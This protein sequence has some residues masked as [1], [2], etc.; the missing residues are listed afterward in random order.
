MVE[1]ARQL[2]IHAALIFL[3]PL[4]HAAA[5][6]AAMTILV[7]ITPAETTLVPAVIQ[8]IHIHVQMGFADAHQVSPTINM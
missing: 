4:V 5:T 2:A 6:Q 3:S 1:L 8:I 7:E